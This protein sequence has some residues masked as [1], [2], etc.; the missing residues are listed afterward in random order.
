[1]NGLAIL[2]AHVVA[3]DVLMARCAHRK[4]R[5]LLQQLRGELGLPREPG[6]EE[7]TCA[8][9]VDH[10]AMPV[11][12]EAPRRDWPAANW[13][14]RITYIGHDITLGAHPGRRGSPVLVPIKRQSSPREIRVPGLL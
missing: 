14:G 12:H 6:L 2:L 10:F 11:D 3:P 4:L 8:S 13:A 1:V 9:D 5:P 7:A